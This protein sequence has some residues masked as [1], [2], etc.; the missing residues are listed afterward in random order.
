MKE[1]AGHNSENR[2]RKKAHENV[3][4]VINGGRVEMECEHDH[5]EC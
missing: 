4:M 2:W 1:R 3:E 5:L